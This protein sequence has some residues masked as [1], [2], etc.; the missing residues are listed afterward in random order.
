MIESKKSPKD[1]AEYVNRQQT[2][3]TKDSLAFGEETWKVQAGH[4][5]SRRLAGLPRNHVRS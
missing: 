5:L 2:I 4:L 1:F 3:E